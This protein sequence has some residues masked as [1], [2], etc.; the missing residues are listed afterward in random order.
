M[1]FNTIALWAVR[2]HFDP[3]IWCIAPIRCTQ[4]VQTNQVSRH[5]ICIT[6]LT[7]TE[8]HLQPRHGTHTPRK[9]QAVDL[10]RRLAG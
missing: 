7:L 8:Q 2:T 5:A 10:H 6:M 1:R 4:M 3:H 9:R